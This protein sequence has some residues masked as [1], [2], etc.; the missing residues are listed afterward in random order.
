M[1]DLGGYVNEDGVITKFN[2]FIRCNLP[3][4]LEDE[5]IDYLK[6]IGITTVID[7][8]SL[9]ESS[10]TKCQLNSDDFNYYNVDL[11]DNKICPFELEP[12]DS[13]MM[14]LENK[15]RVYQ[16][17]KIIANSK[18]GV[19]YHCTAGKDRTG[20]ITML[21]LLIANV[22]DDDII[23][24]Y[25]VSYTYLRKMIRKMRLDDP[26]LP[27]YFGESKMETMEGV[28]EAFYKKYN[29]VYDYLLDIGITDYEFYVIRDMLLK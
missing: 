27:L 16:V 29:S 17:F 7:L 10:R 12:V 20:I 6:Q 21:L 3:I 4:G 11:N 23:A 5:E 13:Y 24:D 19:L 28:L 1:R 14:V 2:R 22:Y 15:E 18:G 25:E 9:K 8:R 26:N